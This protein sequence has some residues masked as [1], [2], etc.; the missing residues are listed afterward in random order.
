VRGVYRN[1][2]PSRLGSAPLFKE[3]WKAW[4]VL[5]FIH[6]SY[7]R[8]CQLSALPGSVGAI[9]CACTAWFFLFGRD[10]TD[11][12]I[13]RAVASNKPKLE[14]RCFHQQ[15]STLYRAACLSHRAPVQSVL[16]SSQ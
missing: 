1:G 14:S 3:R 7:V 2:P 4:L 5:H 8:L 15:L 12:D 9:A 13:T 6:F 11:F 10:Y 16:Q